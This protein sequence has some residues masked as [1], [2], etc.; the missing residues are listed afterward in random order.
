MSTLIPKS[1]TKHKRRRIYNGDDAREETPRNGAPSTSRATSPLVAMPDPLKLVGSRLE[2]LHG[3]LESQ[4]PS[5]TTN[6]IRQT[7]L[8]LEKRDKIILRHSNCAK[9]SQPVKDPRTGEILL[10][11]DD[12]QVKF[13]PNSLRAACPIKA[14]KEFRDDPAMV[15]LLLDAQLIQDAW[16]E[17]MAAAA[18]NVAKLEVS[19]RMGELKILLYNHA[20]SLTEAK[21]VELR[22]RNKMQKSEASNEDYATLMVVAVLDRLSFAQAEHFGF[23]TT[24]PA[25]G[26][27]NDNMS[28]SDG[29]SSTEPT[30]EDRSHLGNRKFADDFLKTRNSNR[31][32]MLKNFGQQ[33]KQ[34]RIDLF[35]TVEELFMRTT[36]ELWEAIAS[37]NKEREVNAAIK[38][39]YEP[40][41]IESATEEVAI[42]MDTI[43]VDNP[44]KHLE[45]YI[46]KVVEG[47]IEK[48]KTA[49]KKK[50]RKNCGADVESQTPTPTENGRTSR[51]ES[52]AHSRSSTHPP[53]DKKQKGRNKKTN[54][55][56]APS[57]GKGKGKNQAKGPPAPSEKPPPRDKSRRGGKGSGGGRR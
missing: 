40:K 35:E 54:P 20:L 32:D 39:F 21:C 50:E 44:T 57:K 49:A 5:L 43:D 45:D 15:K 27:S 8:M 53:K 13:V 24:A 51:R 17:Q 6:I 22:I 42:A 34:T 11:E 19:L 14:S 56:P 48:A 30:A 9:F 25:A 18:E 37:K 4:P 38:K 36:F 12:E 46:N 31:E 29:D 41:A 10:N 2:P 16:K 23:V 1:A 33:N 26:A 3:L 52:S 28:D 47:R 7:R 55:Q